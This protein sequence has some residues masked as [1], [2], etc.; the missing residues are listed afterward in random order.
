M[1]KFDKARQRNKEIVNEVTQST[2]YLTEISN[3]HKRVT[4]IYDNIGIVIGDIDQKFQMATKLDATDMAFLFFATAMQVIRQYFITNF[5][6]SEDRPNDQ[7]AAEK[8]K[9]GHK[10]HSDRSHRYYN[11]SLEEII[12]NPV[13]FDAIYG[14]VDF[15]LGLGGGFSH[16]AKTLGHDAFLGWIFGTANIATST[17]TTW[18]FDSYHIKTGQTGNGAARDKITNHASTSKVLLSTK[19]KLLHEEFEGKKKVGAALIKEAVHLKSDIGSKVSLPIPIISTISPEF[20][21]SLADYGIDLA[22]VINVGKQVAYAAFINSIV[23]MVHRLLYDEATDGSIL[24]YEVRTRKILSY[25]NVI[26]S[27][28]NI[29]VVAIMEAIGVASKDPDMVKKGL[30]YLDVGGLLVTCYRLVKDV[31]FINQ[32]KEEFLKNEF[33]SAVVGEEYKFIQEVQK[34]G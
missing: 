21:K 30:S 14:S 33:Y 16:R 4:N 12:T 19:D 9:G 6:L 17:L 26:A 20:A 18:T 24:L 22:N 2:G 32:V 23:S 25:S 13:P 3:E 5:K 15:D 11:P 8:T 28:S 29:I 7:E 27:L 10:E 34:N 1:N 31:K